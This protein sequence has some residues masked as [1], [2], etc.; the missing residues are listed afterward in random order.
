MEKSRAQGKM[1]DFVDLRFAELGLREIGGKDGQCNATDMDKLK[2]LGQAL[3]EGWRWA[4]DSDVEDDRKR[5]IAH[6]EERARGLQSQ[7]HH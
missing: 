2:G 4:W 5:A 6:F 1:Y 7:I 3:Y